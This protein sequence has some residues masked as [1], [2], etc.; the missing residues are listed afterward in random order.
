MFLVFPMYCIYLNLSSCVICEFVMKVLFQ[1]SLELSRSS[2]LLLN[3]LF[4]YVKFSYVVFSCFTSR[5]SKYF[6]RFLIGSL[7]GLSLCF[8]VFCVT[9]EA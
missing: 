7:N 5:S 2:S 3:H 9:N 6:W 4:I 8:D 1:M